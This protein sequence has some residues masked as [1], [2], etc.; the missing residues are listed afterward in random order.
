MQARAE[1]VIVGAGIAGA[2]IAYHLAQLGKRDVVVVER[3]ALVSGTT[4]HAPGLV[5]QLRSSPVLTR[6]LMDSVALYR[7]LQVDGVAG[8]QE[9]G[10]LRVASSKERFA[11]LRDQAAFAAR[12]GL[13]AH[14]L[15]PTETLERFPLMNPEGVE[16]ALFV[17]S[18]GSAIAPVLAQ[19]LIRAAEAAG[20]RFYPHAPVCSVDVIDNRV[21][22][23]ET[24]LGRIET[25][26]LVVATGI[27]SPLVGRLARV[28][29]A[30]TPMQH[31]YAAT[32]PIAELAGRTLPNLRDPDKLVYLRQ[33]G[34]TLVLGGY[35][36]D[37]KPFDAAAIPERPDPTVHSFDAGHFEPLR[38][39]AAERVPAIGSA[40][41]GRQVN[42]LES[43]TPDGEFLLGPSETVRGFWAACGFCAHGVSSAGGVGRVL[44]QWIAT[45]DPGVDLSVT[46]L[47]RFGAQAASADFIRHGACA[48]Y[49]TYYD[50][51]AS[52]PH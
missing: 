1:I 17:P 33:H 20:V 43:F 11:Q 4:S 38:R 12:V 25:E 52:A 14:L 15:G 30:L 39:A 41:L 27:W 42:G 26:T 29:L 9:V 31:Q 45:G 32:G 24:A 10:S 50:I 49:R 6:M 19:A 44:A 18:D 16:G 2:S 35:E 37:P 8:F 34:D 23:V 36:R 28:P 47:E 7:G 22:G 48:V 51:P 5:G 21:R 46:R 13:E 3:G 40:G